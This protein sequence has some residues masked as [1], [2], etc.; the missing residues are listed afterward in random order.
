MLTRRGPCMVSAQTSH[1]L[2][3]DSARTQR[4]PVY[5]TWQKLNTS[6]VTIID[7]TIIVIQ[8][9]DDNRIADILYITIYRNL[10]KTTLKHSFLAVFHHSQHHL[11]EN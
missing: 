5:T 10:P 9:D 2:C 3:M 8:M 6:V 7:I 4:G 11:E 1:R